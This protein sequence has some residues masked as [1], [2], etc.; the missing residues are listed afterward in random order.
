[1]YIFFV[2]FILKAIKQRKYNPTPFLILA[3]TKADM[4]N[5]FGVDDTD[6]V[7]TWFEESINRYPR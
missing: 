2:S 3:K 1:M 6:I 4:A 5:V 7:G